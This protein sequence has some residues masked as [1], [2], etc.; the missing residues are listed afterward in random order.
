MESYLFFFLAIT[1]TFA[2]ALQSSLLA[3]H[4]RSMD[5]L[6]LAFYRMLA[7][8]I[9][10]LP[11]LSRVSV[12]EYQQLIPL[13]P[14]F[15]LSGLSGG[16]FLWTQFYALKF[17]PIGVSSSLSQSMR[18]LISFLLS[19]SFLNE[20]LSLTQ[21]AFICLVLVGSAI[22]AISKNRMSH[23]TNDSNKGVFIACISGGFGALS[24][25]SLS[26]T[27]KIA[28]PYMIGYFWEFSVLLGAAA[29]LIIRALATNKKL[30]VISIR[31]FSVISLASSPTL[32]G[33]ICAAL[34]LQQGPLAIFMAIAAISVIL[35]A[36]FGRLLYREKLVMM[37]WLGV[38][39]SLVG[40]VCLKLYSS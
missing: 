26:Y 35:S 39:L 22:V 11:M 6:S 25:F 36:I 9:I 16:L 34:A 18:T 24:F 3:H 31:Q 19:Y 7:L 5:K 32:I 21:A 2:Y 33:T 17:L 38:L 37:Q 4:A 8:S 12:D 10:L 27:S 13:L 15:A 28:N 30:Q 29:I 40:V 20:S 1:S 23:L 14:A